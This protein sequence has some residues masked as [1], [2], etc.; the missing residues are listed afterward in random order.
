MTKGILGKKV[1]M[2]QFFTESG[3][4]VPVTVIEA[5]P[6]V[7]LQVKTVETDGYEAVQLGFDDKREKL[8]NKPHKGHVAKAETTPKRFIKE[9]KDVELG[10]YET[11]KEVTVELFQAGDIVDVTGTSKGKGFQGNI[12]R[13]GQARGPMSHGSHFHR[14]PGSIGQASDAS[15]VWKGKELPGRMGG[16]RITIQNLEIVKVDAERNVILIKGNVPGAKKS[17]IEI[18]SAVKNSA[19]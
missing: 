8:A 7:V 4:L 14:A 18:K 10:E 12:K 11:G 17:L 1:G 9:F 19:E 2:T 15:R 16:E 5:Q 13:H 3:E 6:N